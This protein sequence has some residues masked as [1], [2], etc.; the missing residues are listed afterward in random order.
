MPMQKFTSALNFISPHTIVWTVLAILTITNHVVIESRNAE[1]QAL[2][3]TVTV[4]LTDKRRAESE[5][6][7]WKALYKSMLVMC[8]D[9]HTYRGGPCKGY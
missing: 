6:E 8:C 9:I 2:Q 7:R 4:A 3:A 5:G 1:I